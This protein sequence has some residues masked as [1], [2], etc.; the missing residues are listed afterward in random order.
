MSRMSY[1]W[2]ADQKRFVSKAAFH[3]QKQKGKGAGPM[4]IRDIEPYQSMVDGSMITS[5][6]HHRN[7]LREHGKIEVGNEWVDPAPKIPLP[8]SAPD[9]AETLDEIGL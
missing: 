7:H 3:A 9:V 4:I 6:S 8:T 1:V 2:D 5:R